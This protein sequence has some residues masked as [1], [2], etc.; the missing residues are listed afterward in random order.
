MPLQQTTSELSGTRLGHSTDESVVQVRGLSKQYGGFRA[1]DDCSLD[2]FQGDVFGLL[3]PNGA[4]KTTLIR[5]LL[6]YLH[7][8][9]GRAVVVGHD[10][11][12]DPVSV[13]QNVAYLPGDARLPR[14]HRGT[15]L[16]RFFAQLHPQGDL[17]RSREVAERL[18]LD[19]RVRVGM[20]STG[21]RQK[22]ALA[23]VF[24]PST[25]LLI[26]DEPTANLDPTVRATVLELVADAHQSGRTVMFSSHVLSEIEESCNRVVFLR[27]GVLARELLMRDLFQRHRVTG[28]LPAGRT[29]ESILVPE[30]LADRLKLSSIAR[31]ESGS[32]SETPIRI[33]TSGDLAPM[34]SWISELGLRRVKI[35]PLGLRAVYNSVH[36]GDAEHF[37]STESDASENA[38]GEALA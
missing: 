6:G 14:H 36:S 1:L 28:E 37:G 31:E 25:P 22:L 29:M 3:G 10:P 24:G 35:E 5:S 30:S 18:E 27:R 17:D 32:P 13:R 33:D 16:L 8:T 23:V 4:G 34:L 11:Q 12:Q 9:S 19:L 26:L 38:I 21:M 15:T 7:P 2:V 20:M